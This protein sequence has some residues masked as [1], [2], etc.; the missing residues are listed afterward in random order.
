[1]SR[2]L[3]GFLRKN[4]DCILLTCFIAVTA[5][6]SCL[7]IYNSK[8]AT[9]P[10]RADG[11]GYYAY[12][13]T[14]FIDH[15]LSFKLAA[16]NNPGN[17]K[18]TQYTNAYGIGVDKATGRVFDKYMP[19]TAMLE[20]PFFVS[21][22]L[23]TKL[24]GEPRTGYSQP[25]Q[26]AI[27]ASG[28]F[29]LCLGSLLLY[30]TIRRLFRK[31]IAILTTLVMVFATN[32]FHYGTFDNSFSQIYSYA[33]V[34]LYLYLLLK[35]MD[36]G[37]KDHRRYRWLAAIGLCLGLVVSVRATDAIVAL[38]LLPVFFSRA[39]IRN[40]AKNISL[41]AVSGLLALT[42]ML[43]YLK[44]ATGSVLTNP[45]HIFPLYDHHYEGFT[46]L[47]K[48]QIINFLFSVKKGLFFWSPALVLAFASVGTL[49]K[50]K[51]MRGFGI[52]LVV[53]LCLQIYLCASW[54]NWQFGGSFGSR[55]FVDMMPLL[56][57]ALATGIYYA[58]GRNGLKVMWV[59]AVLLIALNSTLMYSYWRGYIAIDNETWSMLVKLP[60]K[61]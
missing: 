58:K 8:L 15:N 24:R 29:Y 38:L 14:V 32:V 52:A 31:H 39:D 6:L 40:S 53:V 56:G 33:A 30:A 54:W 23:F 4:L 7:Y 41:V 21:A 19:G 49:I 5:I 16:E 43:V 12:L 44:H 51:R 26:V 22:D 42:P 3:P 17:Y 48:P 34:A 11:F 1:M 18:Y 46:R 2:L 61:L 28:V 37:A 25:Y 27:V 9:P 60:G 13:P 50:R 45:Y 20:T 57:L 59:L 36:L 35:Y 10:I 55:P 47:R